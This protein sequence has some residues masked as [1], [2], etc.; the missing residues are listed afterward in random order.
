[1]IFLLG[2][3]KT[4]FEVWW[5]C[6]TIKRTGKMYKIEKIPFLRFISQAMQPQ[7]SKIRKKMPKIPRNHFSPKKNIYLKEENDTLYCT[8]WL[9][10]LIQWFFL[11]FFQR[12]GTEWPKYAFQITLFL[13]F[14][15]FCYSLQF[16]YPA[17]IQFCF[18]CLVLQLKAI[19]YTIETR[20]GP[21]KEENNPVEIKN[22]EMYTKSFGC[23]I[24]C[25]KKR[26]LGHPAI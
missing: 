18:F 24:S 21:P 1:M 7:Y 25:R 9:K 26:F 11:K 23:Y 15:A 14:R 19:F 4:I 2:Q 8:F 17:I 22:R 13:K 12:S 20:P 3:K 6:G 10:D 16:L 5:I